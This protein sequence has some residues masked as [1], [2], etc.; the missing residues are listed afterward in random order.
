V[1]ELT[2]L[3]RAIVEVVSREN[4]SDFRTDDLRVLKR[5][6]TGAGRFT[7]LADRRDQTLADGSYSAQGRLVELPGVRNG[8]GFIVDI[9]RS[10]ISH[11]ELFTFGNET[12]DGSEADW[13]IV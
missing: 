2:E 9:S 1:S 5:E 10:R 3:E 12:W 11:I 13:K 4:W 7:Y 6:N 8:L